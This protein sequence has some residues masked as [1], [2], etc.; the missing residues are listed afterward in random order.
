MSC[1]VPAFVGETL[2]LGDRLCCH[3]GV[4]TFGHDPYVNEVTQTLLP[5]GIV[6]MFM[7]K[8]PVIAFRLS[9]DSKTLTNI[10]SEKN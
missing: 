10:H 4:N 5:S 8:Y 1:N 7:H 2:I 6:S 9:Y 3:A